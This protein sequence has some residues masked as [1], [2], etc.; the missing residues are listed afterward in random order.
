MP[1]LTATSKINHGDTAVT[2]TPTFACVENV[3]TG[4]VPLEPSR[5]SRANTGHGANSS[6]SIP[7]PDSERRTTCAGTRHGVDPKPPRAAT[8]TTSLVCSGIGSGSATKAPLRL[9]STT[10]PNKDRED[11][12][13]RALR[14]VRTRLPQRCSIG[15]PSKLVNSM[16]GDCSH[17]RHRSHK[18]K[19]LRDPAVSS[20]PPDQRRMNQPRQRRRRAP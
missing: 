5:R 8:S 7:T 9:R 1:S 16:K 3:P 12:P 18:D 19:C 13:S 6:H 15:V 17:L 11:E 20:R 10:R 14:D 4:P 2:I